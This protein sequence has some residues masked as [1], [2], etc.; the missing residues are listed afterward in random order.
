MVPSV[1]ILWFH[2]ASNPINLLSMNNV[3]WRW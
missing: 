2:S 3:R 1:N